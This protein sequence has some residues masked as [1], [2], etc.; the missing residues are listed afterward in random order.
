MTQ[1]R[2]TIVD[3]G[4]TLNFICSGQFQILTDI[5]KGMQS[6]LAMPSEVVTEIR[7]KAKDS[8]GGTKF[9]GADKKLASLLAG[10]VIEELVPDTADTHLMA[11]VQRVAQVPYTARKGRSKDLGEVMV[12]AHATVRA[13]PEHVVF[14]LIDDLDGQTLARRHRT[15]LIS[16]EQILKKGIDYGLIGTRGEMKVIYNK[17]RPFDDGLIHFDQTTLASKSLYPKAAA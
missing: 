16:T 12:V 5:L 9:K 3:A 15:N 6:G 17:L 1:A 14:V 2:T 8:R 7:G 11:A 13:S 10:D 4:P